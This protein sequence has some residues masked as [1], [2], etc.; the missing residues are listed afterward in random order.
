METK[1]K[2][3]YEAKMFVRLALLSSLGFVFYYAHLF[4]G[5]LDNAFAFKALAVTFLLA[6]V[7]LP[8]IALNNKKL[9][10]ELKRHGK[11]A[12]AMASVL[13]LVHHF[14]MTFI[15][16]LFLQGRTVL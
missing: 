4:L 13:L 9:F 1:A 10:P 8:I 12:L 3:V 5:F 7:P 11:T 15:F 14:L 16:V 2:M 6:A